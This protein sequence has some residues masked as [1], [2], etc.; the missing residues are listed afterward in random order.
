MKRLILALLFAPSLAFAQDVWQRAAYGTVPG[1]RFVKLEGWNPAITTTFETVWPESTLHVPAT[2][3]LS[4]PYCASSDTNDT[5]AGTGARTLTLTGVNTSYA[6]FT[7]TVTL[8]GQTSV[9]LTTSAVLAIN[10]VVVATA[11]SGGLNAGVIDCGTGTNSAGSA[12]TVYATIPA[13]ST[14]AIPAAGTGGGMVSNGFVYTVPANKTLLCRNIQVGSVFATAAAG[15]DAA[16]DG[17]TNLGLFKRFW[18]VNML[19]NTGSNPSNDAALV[20][21]PAKTQLHA[22]IAGVTG[23]STGPASMSAECLLIT[24]FATDTNQ[25]WF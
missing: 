7:E 17:Y 2:A 15:H 10:S 20:K 23:T 19:H 25:K 11:G 18:G 9:N 4:T 22:K 3:A 5:A 14:S 1:V 16:I 12:A 6:E 24:D 21:F 8:N 13:S